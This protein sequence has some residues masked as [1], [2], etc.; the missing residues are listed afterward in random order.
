MR[1]AMLFRRLPRKEQDRPIP[2]FILFQQGR[3]G[4]SVAG[5]WDGLGLRANASAPV[6]LDDCQVS[7]DFQLTD[8][9]AGFPDHAKRGAAAV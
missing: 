9:G 8:D 5:P 7:S 1:R 4:L 6:T 3:A 2:R